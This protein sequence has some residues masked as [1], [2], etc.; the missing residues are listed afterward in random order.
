MWKLSHFE[1]F[2]YIKTFEMRQFFKEFAIFSY[3]Q[4]F[5][6][7]NKIRRYIFD[8]FLLIVTS[9]IHHLYYKLYESDKWKQVPLEVSKL[10]Y[11]FM[12]HNGVVEDIRN[13]RSPIP[14]GGLEVKLKLTFEGLGD[15]V[16]NIIREAYT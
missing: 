4:N 14:S 15:I 11:N 12:C 1:R 3:G 6:F 5:G 13:R 7:Q 16:Y 10:C 2:E 9:S 8:V